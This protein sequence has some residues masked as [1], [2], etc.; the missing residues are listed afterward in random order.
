L[1]NETGRTGNING[2]DPNYFWAVLN[3]KCPRCRKGNMFKDKNA[4]HLNT[5]FKMNERCPVCGQKT[6]IERGF[7]YG[8]GYVSY[9][10][11]V[12]FSTSTFIAWWVL[13]GIS[14]DDNRIY[15]WLGINGGLMLL[16]QPYF[17]RLSRAIWLSFFVKYDSHWQEKK[18]L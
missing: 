12:A 15:W 16:L 2:K 18:T 11:T 4:Y 9:A 3:Q 8:T 13:I 17:M 7:Y 1:E 5:L 10:L 14:S 6:E